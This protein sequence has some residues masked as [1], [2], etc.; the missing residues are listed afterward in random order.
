MGDQTAMMKK[1]AW[2]S[3]VE[4]ALKQEHEKSL[5]EFAQD[6]TFHGVKYIFDG[7]TSSPFR[8]LVE[9]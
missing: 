5:A 3:T 7:K 2:Q 8:R 9:W 1:A 6:T 4:Q